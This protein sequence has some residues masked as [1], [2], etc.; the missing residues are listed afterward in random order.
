MDA[1]SDNNNDDDMMMMMM[2]MIILLY[3]VL[4]YIAAF[5]IYCSCRGGHKQV[6]IPNCFFTLFLTPGIFTTGG[7]KIKFKN[8]NNNLISI[9]P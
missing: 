8:N 3:T 1:Y 5:N 2:M 6:A 4:T 7:I 9:Q